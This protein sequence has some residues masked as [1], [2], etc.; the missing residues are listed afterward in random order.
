MKQGTTY[1]N[2][3]PIILQLQ[4]LALFHMQGMTAVEKTFPQYK[5]FV[6]AYK[7]EPF[8]QVKEKLLHLAHITAA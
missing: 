2:Q 1:G 5:D 6:E 4:A 3:K 7:N 8:Q